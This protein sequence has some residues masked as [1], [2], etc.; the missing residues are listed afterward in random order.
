MKDKGIPKLPKHLEKLVK[1]AIK[2]VQP[3]EPLNRDGIVP[4]DTF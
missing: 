2:K 3:L 1:L 4:F